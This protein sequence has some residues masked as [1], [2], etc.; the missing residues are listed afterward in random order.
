MTRRID[1]P[2]AFEDVKYVLDLALK[3]PGLIYRL[4]SGGKATYFKQRCNQYRVMLRKIASETAAH[5]PGFRPEI[6][7]DKLTIRQ[8]DAEGNPSR[9]GSSLQ[10]VMPEPVGELVDPETGAAISLEDG[11]RIIGEG[12]E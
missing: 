3:R 8:L 12:S 10:F 1:T 2:T 11:R 5:A 4:E 9:D 6:S 7:Y